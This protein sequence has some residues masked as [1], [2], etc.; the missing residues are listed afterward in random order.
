[1]PTNP[2]ILDVQNLV[3]SAFEA[4]CTQFNITGR[5]ERQKVLNQIAAVA[6][7]MKGQQ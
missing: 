1:M 3:Q 4:F 6:R 2:D 7:E 5:L